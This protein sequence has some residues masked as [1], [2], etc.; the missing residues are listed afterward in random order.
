VC[1]RIVVT[2]VSATDVAEDAIGECG[3]DEVSD[4]APSASCVDDATRV[5]V[6]SQAKSA[7]LAHQRAGARMRAGLSK[8][9][10]VVQAASRTMDCARWY[11]EAGKVHLDVEHCCCEK[12]EGDI[13][14][15][16][17]SFAC[18]IGLC[19]KACRRATV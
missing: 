8:G 11:G 17:A 3:Q 6:P 12:N 10:E 18:V 2:S 16:A 14:A 15:L 13:G 4:G 7:R 1:R 5:S 9:Q 19:D